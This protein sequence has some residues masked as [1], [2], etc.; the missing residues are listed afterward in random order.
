MEPAFEKIARLLLT[1]PK[2]AWTGAE[3]S[4][5]T[6]YSR[7]MVSRVLRQLESETVVAKPYKN[8]FVLVEPTRLLVRWSC[9]RTLPSPVYVESRK[10]ESELDRA[11]SR[12][13][14]VAL[15]QF[16]GAWLRSHYMRTASYDIYVPRERTEAVAKSLGKV[17]ESP[18]LISFLPAEDGDVFIGSERVDGMP[19]VSIPQN[20]VDLMCTGGSGPRVALHLGISSG[21]LGV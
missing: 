17:S 20:F 6:G 11:I 8:R 12:M 16:R 10:S 9:S 14:V 5:R 15:T 2:R 7:G 4:Q 19:V 18:Q 21:L 13:K 1:E 3:L